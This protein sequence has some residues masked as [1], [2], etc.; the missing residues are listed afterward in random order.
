[1]G[2]DDK[3]SHRLEFQEVVVGHING[4]P[5]FSYM[6][7]DLPGQIPGKTEATE[8]NVSF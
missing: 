8:G 4:W 5:Q 3:G 7:G 2:Q 6:N 1:M